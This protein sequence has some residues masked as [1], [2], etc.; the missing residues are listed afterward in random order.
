MARI[1]RAQLEQSLQNYKNSLEASKSLPNSF[2]E[3]NIKYNPSTGEMEYDMPDDLNE[4]QFNEN[5]PENAANAR[6][7]VKYEMSRIDTGDRI[8]RYINGNREAG[9]ASDGRQYNFGDKVHGF[10]TSSDDLATSP[11]GIPSST[12]NVEY[13]INDDGDTRLGKKETFTWVIDVTDIISKEG[14]S[15]FKSGHKNPRDMSQHDVKD[16]STM[17]NARINDVLA[18]EGDFLFTLDEDDAYVLQDWADTRHLNNKGNKNYNKGGYFFAKRGVPSGTKEAMINNMNTVNDNNNNVQLYNE[19]NPIFNEYAKKINDFNKQYNRNLRVKETAYKDAIDIATQTR[20]ADYTDQRDK[21]RAMKDRMVINQ[22]IS[23]ENANKILGDVESVFKDFYRGEKLEKFDFGYGQE[24]GYANTKG[25]PPVGDFD[26]EYY[27]TQQLKYQG[28]TEEE[29]WNQA[30][31]D[32]DIDIT[33][34]YGTPGVDAER[35]YYLWRYGQAKEPGGNIRGNAAKIA[36]LAD[37]YNEEAPTE[38]EIQFYR[39]KMLNISGIDDEEPD[40]PEEMINSVKYIKDAYEEAKKAKADGTANRFVESAGTTFNIDNPDE[41]LLI[42]QQSQNEDDK[43]AFNLLKEEG[44]YITELEDVITGVVGE[45][46]ILQT[47]KFG[48]LTQNVLKDTI[49]ELKKAKAKEQ[50]LALM[51]EFGTF[52]E[53][54]DVNSSLADSLL[55]DSGIG[56]YLPFLGKDSGFDKKTLEKQLSGVTGVSNNV[57]YNW[58]KWFDDSLSKAYTESKDNYITIGFEV[59]EAEEAAEQEIEIQRSFAEKYINDYLKPRFDESRSMNEFVEYLDV[60]TTEQN[61]FQTQTMLNAV[62]SLGSAQAKKYLEDIQKISQ[63]RPFDSDFYFNP[64]GAGRDKALEAHYAKQKQTVSADWEAAKNNPNQLVDPNNPALGTWAEKIYEY[65][66][67]ISEKDQFARFHY[68]VK[69]QFNKDANGNDKKFDG[70]E[71][72]I[73][74]GLVKQ[75]IYENIIPKLEDESVRLSDVFGEF[76]KPDEYAD[77]ILAGLDPLKNADEWEY[78]LKEIG[79]E[80][81]KGSVDELKDYIAETFRTG[82]AADMRAQIKYLNEKREKP[83][84]ELLGVTYIQREEDYKT[85]AKLKSDTQLFK[86]FQNAGYEGT[87]EEFY[88]EVFPDIDPEQQKLLSDL[89][90]NKP[91]GEVFGLSNEDLKNPLGAFE[92]ISRFEGNTAS[93]FGEKKEDDEDEEEKEDSIFSFNLPNNLDYDEE[94]DVKKKGSSFLDSYQSMSIPGF[95]GFF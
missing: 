93:L 14:G 8:Y 86:T 46:A 23:E 77:D 49:N 16:R 74:P 5:L 20:G 32:D 31:A 29:N 30:V 52:G 82:S 88:E 21:I 65:G 70:A 76:I 58:Q 80:D 48:A 64:R 27:K 53:I 51:G 1:S 39:D 87:E 79:L 92:A 26:P 37:K 4:N 33:E 63:D 2:V 89:S 7:F 72:I 22:G 55:G 90:S 6:V 66:A 17:I 91:I 34:R 25:K 3:N 62:Q 60:R 15:G 83:T 57:V 95:S 78:A 69:G 9:I 11:K 10:I 24:L 61:P 54:M 40:N 81:F 28:P 50:E 13:E 67:N 85:D 59:G 56:G 41:F 19:F 84:Q 18:R 35:G 36:D 94:E 71:D 44:A 75:H 68:Q 38:A 45:E 12:V 73:N 42:F 47:K 43:A